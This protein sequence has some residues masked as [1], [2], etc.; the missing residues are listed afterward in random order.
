MDKKIHKVSKV[1]YDKCLKTVLN[2]FTNDE[3]VKKMIEKMKTSDHLMRNMYSMPL[4]L[5]FSVGDVYT[6]S[7]EYDSIM[8]VFSQEKASPGFRDL[9]SSGAIFNMAAMLPYFFIKEMRK[10]FFEMEKDKKHLDIGPYIYLGVLGVD[11]SAQKKGLGGM[12]MDYLCSTADKEGKAIYLETQ[13][14]ENVRW[15]EKYGFEVLK[16]IKAEGYMTLWE[17]ARKQK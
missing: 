8:I 4:K 5:G 15:Y 1:D 12:L 14:P 9:L 3:T 2:A 17:M 13:S 6:T 11:P 7:E 10:L 16:N